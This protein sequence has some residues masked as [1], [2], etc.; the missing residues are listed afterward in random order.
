MFEKGSKEV[1]FLPCCLVLLILFV[2]N[3]WMLIIITVSSLNWISISFKDLSV[4]YLISTNF[5]L[6]TVLSFHLTVVKCTYIRGTNWQ[7]VFKN[8]FF[9]PSPYYLNVILSAL[10][11]VLVIWSNSPRSYHQFDYFWVFAVSS[12]PLFTVGQRT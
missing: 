9:F 5:L 7:R 6:S 4:L 2:S 12:M 1:K 8:T 3:W 11:L 10:I